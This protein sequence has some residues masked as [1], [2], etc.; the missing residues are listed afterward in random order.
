MGQLLKLAW[1]NAWRNWRRTTIAVVA[2]VLGRVLL[3]TLDGV[4]EGSG[5]SADVHIL[6]GV[7]P[8]PPIP[9]AH[10]T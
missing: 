7:S 6:P 10:I 4:I 2:V 8:Y 1:R 9:P 5:T 3:L